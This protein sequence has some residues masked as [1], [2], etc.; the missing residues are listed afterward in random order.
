MGAERYPQAW[1]WTTGGVAAVF[2]LFQAIKNRLKTLVKKQLQY[3]VMIFI[4]PVIL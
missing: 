1:P 3:Q 4:F 2:C